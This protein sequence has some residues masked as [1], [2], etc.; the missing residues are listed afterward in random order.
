[1][2]ILGRA[3][4][5]RG[6]ESQEDN[7]DSASSGRHGTYGRYVGPLPIF[8]KDHPPQ[9]QLQQLFERGTPVPLPF[10]FGYRWHPSQSS[11]ILATP[12]VAPRGERF[13]VTTSNP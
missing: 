12:R 5:G 11:L 1:M 6:G 2:T 10:S 8:V 3:D 4:Y 13:P 9:S 7:L